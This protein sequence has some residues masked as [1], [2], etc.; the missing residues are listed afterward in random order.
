M[1]DVGD[2]RI[3]GSRSS[4]RLIFALLCV[5]F[6]CRGELPIERSLPPDVRD[7]TVSRDD[8]EGSPEGDATVTVTARFKDAA[9]CAA[10]IKAYAPRE[11]LS[12]QGDG[13]AKDNPGRESWSLRCDSATMTYVHSLL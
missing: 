2:E 8:V 6:A 4:G 3:A 1:C 9:G 7:V 10:F 13:W 11:G 12:P 5:A